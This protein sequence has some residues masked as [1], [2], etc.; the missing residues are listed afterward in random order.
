M[1]NRKT[2]IEEIEKLKG[3]FLFLKGKV[4]DLEERKSNTIK[5][6][7]ELL[8][9]HKEKYRNTLDLISVSEVKLS[10]ILSEIEEKQKINDAIS[11]NKS[12]LL[13]LSEEQ[14]EQKNALLKLFAEKDILVEQ[15]IKKQEEL[16]AFKEEMRHSKESLDKRE[17][18]LD[19]RKSE[20]D[21][22]AYNLNNLKD[23]L[24]S[25]KR[26]VQEQLLENQTKIDYINLASKSVGY[27]VGGLQKLM[28]KKK[29]KIDILSELK[30]LQ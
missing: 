16:S 8:V 13:K 12:E 20:L 9:V 19:S 17:S 6:L 29:Y 26:K 27:Y 14:T 3:S 23:A 21:T 4:A 5:E 15:I 18:D 11:I 10:S 1:E 28:D 2:L 7:R 25:E 30:N 22:L 24:Y